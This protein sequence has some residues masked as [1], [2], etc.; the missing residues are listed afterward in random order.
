MH[1]LPAC[2]RLIAGLC[3]SVSLKVLNRVK[4]TAN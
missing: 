2:N 4:M 3:S 1:G